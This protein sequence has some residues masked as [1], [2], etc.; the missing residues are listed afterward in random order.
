M[1]IIPC[2]ENE[3]WQKNQEKL[4]KKWEEQRKNR[5]EE[6]YKNPILCKYCNEPIQYEKNIKRRKF[7]SQSCGAAFNNKGVRRNHKER[8]CLNCGIK[9]VYPCRKFCKHSCQQEFRYSEYIKKWKSGE[10]DGTYDGESMS[11]NIRRYIKEK[12]NHKCR[13]CGWAK[14]NI[15]SNSVPLHIDHI[16]GD[17]TDNREENLDLLCPSCHSLTSTYG[18][19]NRG[20]SKRYKLINRRKRLKENLLG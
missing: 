13:I 9:I 5:I 19:L 1:A 8:N 20:K 12:Y 7:C 14:M 17:C 18:N 4:K 3:N 6:Y 15:Y 2:T 16:N 11:G 10:I